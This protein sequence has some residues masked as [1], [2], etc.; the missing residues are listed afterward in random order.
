MQTIYKM[1]FVIPTF[2]V[3][4]TGEMRPSALLQFQQEV[5]EKHLTLWGMDTPALTAKGLAFVVTRLRVRVWRMPKL[6]EQVVLTTWHRDT[7]GV[8]FFRCYT[9]TTP[10]GVPLVDAVSAFALVDTVNHNLLRPSTLGVDCPAGEGMVCNCPDPS[11]ETPPALI[12]IAAVRPR[13]SEIDQNGHVNNTRYADFLCDNVPS[14]MGQKTIT[15]IA[16]VFE[17]ETRP[18]DRLA[19]TAAE[20]RF[21]NED[22]TGGTAWVQGNHARGV[23]FTGKLC[24]TDS[25]E[26]RF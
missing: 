5:G 12:E 21:V 7:R 3:G 9:W 2:A 22:T 18:D 11:K 8:Q 20:Q 16:L 19:I 25:Y 23:A 17:K 6:D 1:P 24:F 15:E 10:D 14:G 4:A 26:R 13:W